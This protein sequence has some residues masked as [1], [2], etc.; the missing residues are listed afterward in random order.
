MVTPEFFS[1]VKFAARLNV[2]RLI[3]H[4]EEDPE[5]PYHYSKPLQLAWG[6]SKLITT[7][8]L[9]HNLRSPSVVKEVVEFI[10]EPLHQPA[11]L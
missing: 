4:D 5:A 9:G 11:I 7:K 8:G 6:K 3:I 2:P 10:E 1:S